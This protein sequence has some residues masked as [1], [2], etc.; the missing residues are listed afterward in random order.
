MNARTKSLRLPGMLGLAGASILL[1]MLQ[2]LG[3]Q[4]HLVW[5][6]QVAMSFYWPWLAGLPIFWSCRG[7]LVTACPGPSE[8]G[9][10]PDFHGHLFCSA[11]SVRS[12]RLLWLM[13]EFP[14]SVSLRF[15]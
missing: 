2:R 6:G 1:M 3:S 13:T 5:L 15:H 10:R 11:F 12:L 9:W 4:P 8:C 7:V 14:D